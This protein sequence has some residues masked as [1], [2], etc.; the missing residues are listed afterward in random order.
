MSESEAG[1][2]KPNTKRDRT[3]GILNVDVDEAIN[4]GA[5]LADNKSLMSP[6]A[7][8][9]DSRSREPDDVDDACIVSEQDHFAEPPQTE[10]VAVNDPPIDPLLGL[11][12]HAYTG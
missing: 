6:T 9:R 5:G 2:D 1:S 7:S 10:G 3:D 4:V 12:L 11:R 8:V